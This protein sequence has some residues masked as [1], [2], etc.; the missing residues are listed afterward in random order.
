MSEKT[1]RD[2]NSAGRATEQKNSTELMTNAKMITATTLAIVKGPRAIFFI[3]PMVSFLFSLSPTS[4]V[5]CPPDFTKSFSAYAP[6][7]T[8]N[9]PIM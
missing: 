3:F 1:S 9:A 2:V 7:K 8:A 5:I 4:H 6:E